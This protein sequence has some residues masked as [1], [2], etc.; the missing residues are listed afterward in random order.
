M[1]ENLAITT[2]GG[3]DGIG[4]GPLIP[5]LMRFL[6]AWDKTSPPDA[7]TPASHEAEIEPASP[8]PTATPPAMRW[9]IAPTVLPASRAI[10]P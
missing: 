6:Q 8:E 9:A 10:G 5:Q 7:P 1:P 3:P 4:L 2:G